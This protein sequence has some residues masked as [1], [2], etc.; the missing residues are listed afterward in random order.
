VFPRLKLSSNS[1]YISFSAKAQQSYTR[2]SMPLNLSL[3][4]RGR[5]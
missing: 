1:R 5:L 4:L 3:L 2:E